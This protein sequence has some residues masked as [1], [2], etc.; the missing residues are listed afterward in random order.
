M[1]LFVRFLSRSSS[2]FAK[3][4][5][6]SLYPS[7]LKV[8]LEFLPTSAGIEELLVCNGQSNLAPAT[9]ENHDEPSQAVLFQS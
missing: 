4:H 1:Q 9:H 3:F 7:P 2:T 6:E 5:A 8:N